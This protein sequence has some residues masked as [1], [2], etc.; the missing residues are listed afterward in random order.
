MIR[1]HKITKRI[2]KD[3]NKPNATLIENKEIMLKIIYFVCFLVLALPQLDAR[4]VQVD[5]LS[6]GWTLREANSSKYLP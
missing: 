3:A 4:K 1:F 6:K 2:Q 5:E